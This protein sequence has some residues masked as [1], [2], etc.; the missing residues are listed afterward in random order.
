[1]KEAEFKFKV[2]NLEKDIDIIENRLL[3]ELV[4]SIWGKEYAYHKRLQ[5]DKQVL[6]AL[7]NHRCSCDT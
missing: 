2:E 1:M 4:G 7:D 3:A 5:V 6:I